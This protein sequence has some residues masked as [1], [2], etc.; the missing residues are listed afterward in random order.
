[1]PEPTFTSPH[2]AGIRTMVRDLIGDADPIGIELMRLVRMVAQQYDVR[3][4]EALRTTNLS[5]PRWGLLMRLMADERRHG[6][7]GMTPTHLS[8]CQNVSKNTISALLGGLEEQG[9]VARSLDPADKRVFRIHLTD[10]GRA[11]IRETVPEHVAFMNRLVGGLTPDERARLGEL[12]E[13]LH[14]SLIDT[15]TDQ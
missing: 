13:K 5:G 11:L 12:L 2:A 7:G 6:P 8:L 9:L 3:M 4:D 1:M 15:N 10:A 14:R